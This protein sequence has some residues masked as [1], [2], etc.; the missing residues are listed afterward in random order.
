MRPRDTS[1]EAQRMLD[2]HHRRMTPAEKAR[3]L[4]RA[5]NTART[6]QLAGLR[7]RFPEDGEDELELRWSRNRLGPELFS[8]VQAWRADR[9]HE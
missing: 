7:E 1:R 4:R 8:R 2:E 3:L 9:A 5:W 6:L